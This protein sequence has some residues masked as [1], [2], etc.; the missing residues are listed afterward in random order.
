MSEDAI[1]KILADPAVLR[2]VYELVR[3]HVAERQ[4]AQ[5]AEQA[6]IE[7]SR[8]RAIAK[9]MAPIA[10]QLEQWRHNLQQ[11]ERDLQQIRQADQC[12]AILATFTR[13]YYENGHGPDHLIFHR[14]EPPREDHHA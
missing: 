7:A 13:A 12:R 3:Q 11:I 6:E 14:P 4:A 1:R 5:A 8:Q 10:E 9:A 2:Q